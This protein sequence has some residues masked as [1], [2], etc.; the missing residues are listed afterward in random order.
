MTA[1]RV[2]SG[3][4]R[5][6]TAV[7]LIV[8]G[9]YLLIYL[10]RWEW[11]RAIVSGIFFVAAEVALATSIILRRLR[12]LEEAGG[13]PRPADPAVLDRL[14]QTDVD[15]PDPFR[16]LAP[17]ANR[18]SVFVP[19][20]LGAG[21]VLSALAYVVERVGEAT[22]LPVLDRS[23]AGRLAGLAPPAGGLTGRPAEPAPRAVQHRPTVMSGV[24]LV[25]A[26][27]SAGVLG[28]L[29]I[30]ALIEETQ[31]RPDPSRPAMTTITLEIIER[32][33]RGSSLPAAEALWVG[34]RSSLGR[35]LPVDAEVRPRD[36]DVVDLVLE[37]GIGR[38]ATRRLTGC[39]TD[40]KLDL[41]RAEVITVEH[42]S[43]QA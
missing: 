9:A 21:V 35:G 19:V 12:T 29:G 8:S 26:L 31:T 34:C 13:V 30:G 23:L 40:L 28:W 18:T 36:G 7:V 11:N 17:R 3:V 1:A 38:L 2:F 39:L 25:V 42:A 33:P 4:E 22:A 15:R 6:L 24:A 41:I 5:T 43:E 16:W 27:A 10:Y 20:L 14:R 37:P 32:H